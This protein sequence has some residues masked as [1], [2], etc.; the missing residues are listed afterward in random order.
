[1]TNSNTSKWYTSNTTLLILGTV[2]LIAAHVNL[3]IEILAWFSYVPFFLYLRRTTGWKSFALLS[4]FV[5]VGWTLA[6]LKILTGDMPWFFA[7]LYSLPITIFHIPGYLV[8]RAFKSNENWWLIGAG[9]FAISEWLLGALTPFGTWGSIAY[10]RVEDSALLQL[11]SLFG[12]GSISLAILLVNTAITYFIESSFSKEAIKKVLLPTGVVLLI[13]YSFGW[14]RIVGYENRAKK[15][16]TVATI[17]H[18]E[19]GFSFNQ[20][21]A[22]D[23]VKKSQ[24]ANIKLTIDAAKAGAQFVS[25]MEGSTIVKKDN[26]EEWKNRISSLAKTYSI[27]IIAAYVVPLSA[28]P[29]QLSN[30][31][32]WFKPDGTID[33]EYEKNRPVPLAEPVR[34]GSLPPQLVKDKWGN[35]F[36]AA[37]CYDY[38]FPTV[39]NYIGKLGAG[40]VFLPSG[41]WRGIDPIH[42]QMSAVR[43]IENGHSIVRPVNNGL[44][45]TISPI[46]RIIGWRSDYD[47]PAGLLLSDVPSQK[48]FTLYTYIGEWSI[49]LPAFLA[50]IAFWK[51]R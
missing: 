34:K 4:L 3:S 20:E 47:T 29:L 28:K 48:L 12:L 27:H 8:F 42:S 16:I 31:I 49:L 45:S 15:T 7:F 46:G 9:I 5:F 39:A 25:W 13:V 18:D 32:V 43:A 24:E 10:V 11:G 41:D 19:V 22:G 26:E 51:G 2:L 37:I 35:L 30:K 17:D 6:V 21:K 33:H 36:S 23:F 44:S 1:M 40:V 14:I 38:D 50:L